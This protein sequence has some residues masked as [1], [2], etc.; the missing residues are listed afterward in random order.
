[1]FGFKGHER[2]TAA[3]RLRVGTDGTTD[4]TLVNF[5]ARAF[6]LF[7]SPFLASYRYARIVVLN[8]KE[9]NRHCYTDIKFD[10]CHTCAN[11][12]WCLSPRCNIDKDVILFVIYLYIYIR[13]CYAKKHSWSYLPVDIYFNGCSE[14]TVIKSDIFLFFGEKKY[15]F[16]IVL[17]LYARFD[18][19]WTSAAV[20]RV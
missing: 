3:W 20:T 6:F 16:F 17:V 15:A 7:S 11:A 2:L 19:S 9:K 13:V 14:S 1:M 10:H 8:A 5:F 4:S 18:L 12:A